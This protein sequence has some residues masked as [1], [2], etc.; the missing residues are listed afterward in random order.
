MLWGNKGHD[1]FV[2]DSALGGGNVDTIED[3]EHGTDKIWL[4]KSIFPAI[5]NHLGS[6]EFQMGNH[7]DDP[8]DFIIYNKSKGKLFYD[9]DG[10]GNTYSKIKFAEVD[11]GTKLDYHDF[12][13]IDGLAI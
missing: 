5:G 6:G 11:H 9:P 1:K 8:N 7:A 2:F 4:A 12:A 10:D 3:M 13:M